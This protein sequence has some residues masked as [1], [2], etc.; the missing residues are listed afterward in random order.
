M[1]WVRTVRWIAGFAFFLF[2]G[3]IVTR[4]LAPEFANAILLLT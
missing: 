3:L 2:V 4:A 1:I